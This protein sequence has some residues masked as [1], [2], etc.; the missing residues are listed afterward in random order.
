MMGAEACSALLDGESG[1]YIGI[2]NGKVE[3]IPL[4]SVIG[5]LKPVSKDLLEMYEDLD[6]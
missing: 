3:R 2:V 5:K 6:N 4:E 1:K